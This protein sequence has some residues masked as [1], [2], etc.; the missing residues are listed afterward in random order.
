MIH[1]LRDKVH[2]HVIELGFEMKKSGAPYGWI[3]EIED[4]QRAV[5]AVAI[6][7]DLVKEDEF[8]DEVHKDNLYRQAVQ[9]MERRARHSLRNIV[10]EG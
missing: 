7:P 6:Q 5:E 9:R 2:A 3:G 8:A 1:A 4:T 10:K